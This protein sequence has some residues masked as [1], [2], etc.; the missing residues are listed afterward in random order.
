MS[1]ENKEKRQILKNVDDMI[2]FF[3]KQISGNQSGIQAAEGRI[4][5]AHAEIARSTAE[6]KQRIADGKELAEKLATWTAQRSQLE[7]L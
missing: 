1:N 3:E 4:E 7:S 2:R 6:I 5:A